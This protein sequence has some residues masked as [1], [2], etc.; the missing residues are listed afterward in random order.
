MG[1]GMHIKRNLHIVVF[2][3]TTLHSL[4]RER[5]DCCACAAFP[6]VTLVTGSNTL[7]SLATDIFIRYSCCSE[8][9]CS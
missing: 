8:A 1:V 4:K 3:V 9:V 2:S 6:E 7:E 5:L